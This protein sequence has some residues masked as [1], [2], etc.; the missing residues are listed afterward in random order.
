MATFAWNSSAARLLCFASCGTA[1]EVTHELYYTIMD[2]Y[3]G[4]VRC[5]MSHV[6]SWFTGFLYFVLYFDP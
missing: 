4:V 3:D 2:V 6:V 5:F 1:G